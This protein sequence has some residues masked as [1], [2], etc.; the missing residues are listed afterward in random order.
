MIRHL[1]HKGWRI[2]YA[3]KLSKEAALGLYSTIYNSNYQRK[4]ILKDNQRSLVMRIQ[5]N[6]FDCVLKIPKEKNARLWIR[7]LTWFRAGEAFKNLA[8]MSLLWHE[9]IA[10]TQP[11]LAAERR[12]FGMVVNSWLVYEYLEGDS[13]LDHP[14]WYPS[15]IDKLGEIHKKGLLHGDPQIRNFI[16]KEDQIFVIDCNPK[17][18]GF[19]GFDFGYEWAYLRKSAP[20]IEKLL[21]QMNLGKWYCFSIWYD[22]QERKL[23]RWRKKV[24]KFLGVTSA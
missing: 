13:C 6:D 8:S 11:L 24:K 15:V 10:T 3:D 17:R 14:E 20:G 9:G 7:F 18:P 12:Q 2:S 5:A 1:K 23:S 4:V 16:C 22:L 19:T 21:D